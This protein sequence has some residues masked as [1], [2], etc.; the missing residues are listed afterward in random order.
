MRPTHSSLPGPHTQPG[1]KI[2]TVPPACAKAAMWRSASHLARA[3]QPRM[4]SSGRFLCDA[5]S[6]W[7]VHRHAAEVDDALAPGLQAGLR[8]QACTFAIAP[9]VCPRRN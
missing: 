3:Y 6:S 7:S 9:R 8:Q 4:G 1:R 2:T 5:P